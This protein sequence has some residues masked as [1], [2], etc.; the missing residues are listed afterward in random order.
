MTVRIRSPRH[1]RIAVHTELI[2]LIVM[3]ANL[4]TVHLKPI[5]SLMGPTHGCA[6][7]F[8]VIA[9]CRLEQAPAAV[10][11]LALVPGVGGLLALRQ[12]DRGD[13]ARA[14]AEEVIPS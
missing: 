9:T 10:K 3:L 12:L 13:S 1:L 2:S 11:V 7:L 14:Q 8:V 6:Y 4:F 5:S